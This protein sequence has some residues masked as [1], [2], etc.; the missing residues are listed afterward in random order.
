ME[1]WQESLVFHVACDERHFRF[2]WNGRAQKNQRTP[3]LAG[4]FVLLFATCFS[5]E[6]G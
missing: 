4:D 2:V 6:D 5:A 1:K 3:K